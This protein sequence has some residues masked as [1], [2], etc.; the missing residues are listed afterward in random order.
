[1]QE[2]FN[3]ETKITAEALAKYPEVVTIEGSTAR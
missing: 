1:M 2:D 3:I